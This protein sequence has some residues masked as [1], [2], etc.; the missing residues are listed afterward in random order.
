MIDGKLQLGHMKCLDA[1]CGWEGAV[2]DCEGL[3]IQSTKAVTTEG[4]ELVYSTGVD[5]V[6]DIAL[7]QCPECGSEYLVFVPKVKP[8]V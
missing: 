1:D 5:D 2:E 6:D 8:T 4:G 3:T 7:N